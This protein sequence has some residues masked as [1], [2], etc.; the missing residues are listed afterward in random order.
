MLKACKFAE[1]LY[2]SRP[3][4]ND[5]LCEWLAG[6]IGEHGFNVVIVDDLTAL[7]KTHDGVREMLAAMRK[8]KKLCDEMRVSVLAITGSEEPC[9]AKAVSESDL[10]RSS[11][12]CGVADSVFA[13][14]RGRADWR[15]V[16]QTRSRNAPVQWTVHNAPSAQIARAENGW[17]GFAFDERFAAPIDPQTR[18]AICRVRAMRQAGKTW[19]AI[20]A[21][22]G[23]PKTRAVRLFQK[24]TP[25]MGEE[26][27]VA[28]YAE[29]SATEAELAKDQASSPPYEGG[30]D[31][32]VFCEQTGWFSQAGDDPALDNVESASSG[33]EPPRQPKRLPPLLRKEGSRSRSPD[34]PRPYGP[35]RVSVY[36]LK[37]GFTR[38]GEEI[39]IEI[40][41]E[42]TRRPK[43]WY[44][45]DRKG[46]KFKS[47]RD[48]LGITST[49]L[50]PTEFL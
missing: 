42:D 4:A 31:A 29:P 12:L 43:V 10:K 48:S 6:Q 36:D 21:E 49:R 41:E 28:E 19:R 18:D 45:F 39:F 16:I 35:N 17:P 27:F 37:R 8:L 14:G 40:E 26:E 38:D 9:S 22:L 25:E 13:I 11:V 20:S 50:G 5:E 33:R 3:P 7:K 46:T 1:N 44:K 23:I 2:R 30:V 15:Y 47:V 24:W 32:R 34:P